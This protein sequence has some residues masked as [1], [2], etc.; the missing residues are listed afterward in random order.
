MCIKVLNELWSR[1]LTF[2]T[3]QK[4]STKTAERSSIYY[5]AQV[6]PLLN[7]TILS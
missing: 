7:I 2:N 5:L 6:H 1:N 3:E 4:K